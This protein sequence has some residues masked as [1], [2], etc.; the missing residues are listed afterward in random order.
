MFKNIPLTL[1]LFLPPA[2]ALFGMLLFVG[3]TAV[4]L[5]DNDNR[6]VSLEKQRYPT[7][8]KSVV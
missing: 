8:R 6:L 1:K 3:Y 2:I 7:D 5:D 4:Q